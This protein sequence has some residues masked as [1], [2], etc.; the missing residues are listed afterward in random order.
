MAASARPR[1]GL[2]PSC[3]WQWRAAPGPCLSILDKKHYYKAVTVGPEPADINKSHLWGGSVPLSSQ[4][5]LPGDCLSI[6]N[7]MENVSFYSRFSAQTAELCFILHRNDFKRQRE[8]VRRVLQGLRCS[9]LPNQT[10]K[11]FL[12]RFLEI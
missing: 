9:N 7:A 1:P 8:Q 10:V 5:S 6:C 2:P 4:L 12:A 3:R 11:T